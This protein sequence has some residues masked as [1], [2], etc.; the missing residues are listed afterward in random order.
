MLRRRCQVGKIPPSHFEALHDWGF[1]DLAFAP[2]DPVT[3]LADDGEILVSGCLATAF[4]G[5][6]QLFLVR[7]T[8]G[9]ATRGQQ[10]GKPD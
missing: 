5:S 4:V 8:T 9:A 2:A 7:A 6:Q 10:L 1:Y 3:T